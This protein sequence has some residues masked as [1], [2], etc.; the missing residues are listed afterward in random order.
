MNLP[1]DIFQ[2]LAENARQDFAAVRR[3]RA[4]EV[5]YEVA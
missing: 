5:S 3:C 2:W 4:S 1:F